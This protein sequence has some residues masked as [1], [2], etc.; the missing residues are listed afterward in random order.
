MAACEI[1]KSIVLAGLPYD[2]AR[3]SNELASL[4]L[5]LGFGCQVEIV[6]QKLEIATSAIR[7]GKADV[8][9]EIWDGDTDE[10][11]SQAKQDGTVANVG[12][13][14]SGGEEGWFVPRYIV[15][16][17]NAPAPKLRSVQDLNDN[18]NLFT[19]AGEG[20]SGILLSCPEGWNCDKVNEKKLEAY[21]LSEK[22]KIHKARS[23]E[24][25]RELVQ[26]SFLRGLPVLFY[27]WRPDPAL[28]QYQFVKIKEPE[29][30]PNIWAELIASKSP[31]VA[32]AYPVIDVLIGANTK[33]LEAAPQ[34]RTFFNRWRMS[35]EDVS[36]SLV[37]A[38]SAKAASDPIAEEAKQFLSRRKDVWVPWVSNEIAANLF[39]QLDP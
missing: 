5:R 27:G 34:I 17:P 16:G 11:W 38:R 10:T 31:R 12:T 13:N 23:G 30:K 19:R 26:K 20:D 24:E 18:A 4:I 15:E 14:F 3:F 33:F 7:D 22:Y 6:D 29:F 21:Q 25:L 2:S 8:I 39:R 35:S 28:D 1:D 36:V 9:M 32:C 37:S